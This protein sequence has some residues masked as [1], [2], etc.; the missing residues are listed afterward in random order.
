MD[1]EAQYRRQ[2]AVTREYAANARDLRDKEMWEWIALDYEYLAASEERNKQ[3]EL[4]E[5]ESPRPS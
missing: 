1:K 5:F 2:A 3:Y 4:Y